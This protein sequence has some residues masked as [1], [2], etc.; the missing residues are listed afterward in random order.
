MRAL[1]FSSLTLAALLG[2]Q[3]APREVNAIDPLMKSC[4]IGY[5]K[6][7]SASGCGSETAKKFDSYI[8]KADHT[9][10]LYGSGTS[11]MTSC[12]KFTLTI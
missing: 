11:Y 8:D 4:N 12:N 9:C 10:T 2:V 1:S 3:N 7:Y 5:I 6:E